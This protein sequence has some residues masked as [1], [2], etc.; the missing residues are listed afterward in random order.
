M[1]IYPT[2]I[3][4]ITNNPDAEAV[5]GRDFNIAFLEEYRKSEMA[6]KNKL[7]SVASGN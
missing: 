6:K 2:L 7:V 5:I 3:T 4:I 1:V